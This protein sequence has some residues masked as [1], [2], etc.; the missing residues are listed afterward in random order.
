MDQY[1]ISHEPGAMTAILKQLAHQRTQALILICTGL[2]LSFAPDLYV[3]MLARAFL[4]PW[5]VAFG[6]FALISIASGRPWPALAA[7]VA[8]LLMCMAQANGQS[9]APA[10][11]GNECLRVAQ[12]N[13]YQYNDRHE[14]VL[15]AAR[16]THAD[17]ISFQEVD[18]AWAQALTQ[19]LRTLYPYHRIRS[20]HDCYGIAAF[21]KLPMLNAKVVPIGQRPA[22][23]AVMRT[24]HGPVRLLAVHVTSPGS[25]GE[26]HDRQ[27]QLELLADLVAASTMPMVV[28]GDLNTV[29]WD[30]AFHELCAKANLHEGGGAPRATWPATVGLPLV[31]L[32]HVLV[33]SQLGV[34]S[35]RSFTIP[36]SD[37][38]GLV[39]DI[40]TRL[41]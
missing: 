3:F 30:D 1:G 41:P 23:T 33:T 4:W 39:A 9:S 28:L 29:S 6:T 17:L 34:A 24:S 8:L 37:H 10:K 36:G 14:D 31:P 21:S 22:I 20:Q 15:R 27:D 19:G 38:R 25:Y 26:F 5:T 13:L 11:K 18:S 32:D 40:T 16:D 2:V 12:M 35:T 7:V